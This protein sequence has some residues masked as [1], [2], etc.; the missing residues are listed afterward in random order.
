MPCYAQDYARPFYAPS[1]DKLEFLQLLAAHF[2][3]LRGR[4]CND[5]CNDICND[6]RSA[7][8]HGCIVPRMP[9]QV[10]LLGIVYSAAEDDAA[11]LAACDADNASAINITCVLSEDDRSAAALTMEL[12]TWLLLAVLVASFVGATLASSTS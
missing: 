2:V 4:T 11:G 5:I 12:C 10:L 1:V 9:L 3:T 7:A 6:M 8:S